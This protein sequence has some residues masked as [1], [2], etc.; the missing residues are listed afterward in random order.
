MI[1]ATSILTFALLAAT[2]AGA[3]PSAAQVAGRT[4]YVD[5]AT[6][7]DTAAGTTT[8]TA[9]RTLDRVNRTA[10]LPGDVV[11]LKRGCIF[12]GQRLVL[13]ASGTSTAPIT[14]TAYGSGTRPTIRNGLNQDVLVSGSWNVV[15]KLI[16]TH[17]PRQTTSCGQPLGIYYGVNIVAGA[18]DN[19]VRGNLV[20]GAQAG[21]HLATGSWGNHVVGNT[22][23]GNNVLDAFHTNPAA[24]LGAWGVLVNGNDSEIA[25]NTF[26]NNRA[27]CANQG[28]KLMSNTVEIYGGS[29]N[30]V[31]HNRS[32]G[33]RVFSELG[34]S[35]THPAADNTFA[36]NEFASTLADARFVVTR[37][38]RDT[39]YGP[40]SRTT[41]VHNTVYATGPRSQG[42]VCILGCDPS[43]LTMR[44][45]VV[46][47]EEKVIYADGAFAESAD[48]VWNSTGTP[49]AQMPM[50]LSPTTAAADP[51]FTARWSGVLTLGPGSPAVDRVPDVP[52]APFG[53]TDVDLLHAAVPQ[54][55]ARDAGSYE[56]LP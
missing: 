28:Y 33:E 8:A 56:Q 25:W 32:T 7:S 21:V 17:T 11:R 35:S 53:A 24:D 2:L 31:H 20:S 36:Y 23:T 13:A 34:G 51:Q 27:V 4:F 9:W 3:P 29:G 10:L 47:A 40:V 44:G 26:S 54:G 45:N 19:V 52:P 37:G 46:W 15:E 48:V 12:D 50:P 49:F 1:G 38:A 41:V 42:V 18:H 6:G 39:L 14:V 30:V 55:G 43:I 5:C 16:V 22:I